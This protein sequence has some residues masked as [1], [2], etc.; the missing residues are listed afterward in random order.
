[1]VNVGKFHKDELAKAPPFTSQGQGEVAH[2]RHVVADYNGRWLRF[3]TLELA[4]AVVPPQE[5]HRIYSTPDELA[6]KLGARRLVELGKTF[7]CKSTPELWA[8]MQLQAYDPLVKYEELAEKE[9]ASRKTRGPRPKRYKK[10]IAY[11]F[12]FDPDNDGH[13]LAY[14]RMPPQACALVDLIHD[15]TKLPERPVGKENIFKEEE[16]QGYINLRRDQLHTKQDP[17]RI[18]QYYRGKLIVSGFLRFHHEG[19]K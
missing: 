1:M 4:R 13:Q 19:G 7:G 18:F 2:Y 12:Q 17:W 15:L 11:R 9:H 10:K 3:D 14:G 16:L 8:K 6:F 5:H